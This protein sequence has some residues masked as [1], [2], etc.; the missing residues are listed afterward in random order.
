VKGATERAWDVLTPDG[1]VVGLTT[2]A[3]IQ[4]LRGG[5][6]KTDD[7]VRASAIHRGAAS[8]ETSAM[9]ASWQ[10]MHDALE[11]FE[12]SAFVDAERAFA[13][14]YSEIGAGIAIA[15]LIALSAYDVY[16]VS[17][18]YAWVILVAAAGVLVRQLLPETILSGAMGL[19]VVTALFGYVGGPVVLRRLIDA[20]RISPDIVGLVS[21]M[22][23]IGVFC[24]TS[25]IG[26]G[27]GRLAGSAVGRGRRERYRL[28][29][30]RSPLPT[31]LRGR[32]EPA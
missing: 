32:V 2:A 20:S 4:G 15:I 25:G 21:L 19:A 22:T 13:K 16:Q 7:L 30:G 10:L 3:I 26:Y 6:L 12:I 24:V 27:I 18:A 1:T 11:S 5:W 28:P 9:T 31:D 14:Y 8:P 29:S 17:P 23:G